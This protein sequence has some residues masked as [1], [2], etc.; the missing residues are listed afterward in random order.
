[1]QLMLSAAGDKHVC[2]SPAKLLNG[3]SLQGLTSQVL[4][5]VPK[6]KSFQ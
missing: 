1:M 5:T 4:V 2:T 3:C 6:I